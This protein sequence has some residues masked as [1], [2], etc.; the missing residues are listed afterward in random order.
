M[1]RN[2]FKI[3]WRNLWK[4]KKFSFI[5][6]FGLATGM[7]CSLLIFLFVKDELSYDRFNENAGNIYR[8]V[9]DF[10]NDDGSRLPDATTPPALAPAMQ[11]DIPEVST[12]T[13]VFPNWGDNFL[14]TY[15]NKKITEEKLYR[16]DS[17]F[18]DV[19]SFPFIQG[20]SKNAFKELNSIVITESASKRYF[21]N[22]NPVGKTLHVDQLGDLAV[23]SV[24]QDIPTNA[25]F[26]FDFLISTR[27]FAGNIDANWNFY[28]FYTY[29]KVKPNTNVASLT[30]KIQAA[31]KS[32]VT[33]GKNI[34]YVQ[35]LRDIHLT[36]NLKW[37]LEP[38]GD[39]LYV[40]VFAII[41]IFIILI[42]I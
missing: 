35:P 40:Y 30:K 42:A 2:Y 39:R 7:A 28:N 18:F 16:V 15:G 32:G 36:S 8:V 41:A 20:D 21:G 11:K 9:K 6:I 25:H 37:E 31:Y 34:F 3:A 10:V 13:R 33:D 29:V 5:N 19:F 38:N 23:T 14:I 26:H 24:L 27:K 17:S 4:N 22:D 12:V 1:Q